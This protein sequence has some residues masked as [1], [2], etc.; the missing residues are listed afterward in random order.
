MNEQEREHYSRLFRAFSEL[1]G[2]WA[3]NTGR[4]MPEA[5]VNE[6]YHW[7]AMQMIKSTSSGCYG[8]SCKNPLDTPREN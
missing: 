1:V 8:G 5:T 4:R 7:T 6:L 2:L 3:M